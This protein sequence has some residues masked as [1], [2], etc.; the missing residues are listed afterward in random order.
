MPTRRSRQ[1]SPAAR[2][3]RPRQL[4][5]AACVL[6]MALACQAKVFWRQG[7]G[8]NPAAAAQALGGRTL[9]Q[10][11]LRVNGTRG[12]LMVTAFAE[13]MATLAPRLAQAM[14]TDC[15][16]RPSQTM[17]RFSTVDAGLRHDILVLEFTPGRPLAFLVTRP[18][19]A[20]A[21]GAPTWPG[22]LPAP[23]G[24]QPRFSVEYRAGQATFA[25]GT[26]PDGDVPALRNTLAGQFAR[27]GWVPLPPTQPA[28]LT[29]YA[30]GPQVCASL[31]LPG[32]G[33]DG[34][35]VAILCRKLQGA[36]RQGLSP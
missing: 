15:P 7:N 28:G 9:F 20:A 3:S 1:R 33:P 2:T 12:N 19:A 36:N 27:D 35:T 16:T 13:P 14:N 29:W 30:R 17:A 10:G 18:A 34:P 22:R 21:A 4:A 8:S 32:T 5:V 6:L 11:D 31:V 24:L 23:P 26:V 25:T